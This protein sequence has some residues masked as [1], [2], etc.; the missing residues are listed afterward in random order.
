MSGP[1]MMGCEQRVKA[2]IVLE[3]REEWG[4]GVPGCPPGGK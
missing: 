2:P 4:R 3:R 1:E